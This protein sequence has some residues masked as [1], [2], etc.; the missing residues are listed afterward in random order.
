MTKAKGESRK[1]KVG[2]PQAAGRWALPLV[3]TFAVIAL[4]GCDYFGFTPIKDIVAAPGQFEGKEVKIKGK[5]ASPVQLLG[6]RTFS[7]KDEGGE[8]T[9]S[10]N[11]S[12]PA[13]GAEVAVKGAV[14]SAIIV[15]GKAAGLHVAETQRL[16]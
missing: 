14:K 10:T 15:G 7:I 1:A 9:V 6:V 5:A 12:L 3:M 4:A 8:I 16:K 11:G 13:A 2:W